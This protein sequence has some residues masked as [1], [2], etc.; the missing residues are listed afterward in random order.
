MQKLKS[1]AAFGASIAFVAFS[2][3]QGTK[4]LALTNSAVLLPGLAIAP[5]FNLVLVRNSG[6]SFG[7]LA[8]FPPSALIVMAFAIC[9]WLIWMLLRTE[10]LSEIIAF[11]LILGGATGNTIDRIRLGAVTDFLDFYVGQAHWPA[12]NF[13]DVSIFSGAGILVV[14]P[15]MANRI[16]SRNEG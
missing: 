2:L 11:S 8:E 9:S 7:M 6:I 3:D 1:R 13:A 14:W 4:A 12:F 16:N 10:N 5:G 15:L